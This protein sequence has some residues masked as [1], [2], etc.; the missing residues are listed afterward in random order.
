MNTKPR[1]V[2]ITASNRSIGYSLAEAFLERGSS[3][4]I[5]GRILQQANHFK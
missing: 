5:S 4:P 1:S 2:A 3:V